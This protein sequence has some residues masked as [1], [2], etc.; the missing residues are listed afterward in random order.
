MKDKLIQYFW[1]INS[2][3]QELNRLVSE[4]NKP[5][6]NEIV[7]LQNP[8][9]T[10]KIKKDNDLWYHFE[11]ISIISKPSVIEP[12]YSY[13]ISSFRTIF[14]DSMFYPVLK[15]SVFAYLKNL[16]G[17]KTKLKN[18]ILFD[19]DVGLNYF[20]FFSDVLNK[21]WALKEYNVKIEDYVFVVNEKLA[22][23]KYFNCVK[24]TRE[25]SKLNWYIQKETEFIKCDK[26]IVV[27]PWPYKNK[28]WMNSTK[29]LNEFKKIQGP[30]KIFINRHPNKGRNIKNIEEIKVI[31]QNHGFL[32]VDTDNWELEKQIGLFSTVTHLVGIHGAGMTNLMFCPEGFK[33]LEI[34]PSNSVCSHYYWLSKT[35]KSASYNALIGGGTGENKPN[36]KGEFTLSPLELNLALSEMCK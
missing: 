4:R 34:F 6:K 27:K 3:P 29:L 12:T 35:L 21:Y 22:N 10:A 24:R 15:P 31:F 19:G 30:Q 25:L 20:H 28:Y 11:K 9:A 18:V 14:Q 36:P 23:T 1:K 17:E 5:F 32:I 33:V 26:V 13:V 2:S 7:N 8:L 16:F